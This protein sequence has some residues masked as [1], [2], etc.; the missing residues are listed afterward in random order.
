[1]G[2]NRKQEDRKRRG[3]VDAKKTKKSKKEQK[4]RTPNACY[5][6]YGS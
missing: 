4:D 2:F 3:G 5:H 1:M 6:I